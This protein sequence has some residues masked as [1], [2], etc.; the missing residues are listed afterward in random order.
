MEG[1]RAYLA[2][3]ATYADF[4]VGMVFDLAVEIRTPPQVIGLVTLFRRPPDQG[5]VGY[6]LHSSEHGNGYA[7][8]AAEALI[9]HAFGHLDLHRVHIRTRSTNAPAAAVATKLGMRL[10]GRLVEAAGGT[11]RRA[12]MLLFGLLQSEWASRL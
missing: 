1:I 2:K 10:E 3:K 8:E 4:E 7:T 5:E 11:G 6:A 12:D 9:N